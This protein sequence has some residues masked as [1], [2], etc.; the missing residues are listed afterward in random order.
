MGIQI[1]HDRILTLAEA[2]ELLHI[3]VNTLRRWSDQG[4]IVA[5]RFNSRG[6]RRYRQS[7]IVKFLSRLNP[8]G[9]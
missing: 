9:F 3:H 2:A 5:N 6:D 4:K 8:T 1:D 7:D